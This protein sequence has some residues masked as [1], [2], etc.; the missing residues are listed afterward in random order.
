METSTVL[1]G[2]IPPISLP[3]VEADGASNG[4]V[5]CAIYIRVSTDEQAKE[6]HYSLHGQE[7]YAMA[8]IRRR[9]HEGWFHLTTLSDPGYSG[10]DWN[11]PGLL[12][13]IDL[14]KAKKV[15]VVIVYKRERLFRNLAMA[16]SIQAVFDLHNVKVLSVTEG[17][18]D[19][20]PH[21]VITRQIIDAIAQFEKANGRKRQHDMLRIAAMNGDWKGGHPPLGYK[22]EPGSR[23]LETI[24]EEAVFVATMFEDVATGRSLQDMRDAWR[25]VGIRGRGRSGCDPDRRPFIRTDD[26]KRMIRLP[27]YRGVVRVRKLKLNVISQ[28]DPNPEW[29]EFKGKHQ[30]IVSEEI[31]W[32]AN[33]AIDALGTKNTRP[34]RSRTSRSIYPLQGLVRCAHCDCGMTPGRSGS[35]TGMEHRYYRC[36]RLSKGRKESLCST[37]QVSAAALEAAV[38]SVIQLL[39]ANPAAFERIGVDDIRKRKD[40]AAQLQKDIAG[41]DIE[42]LCAQKELENLLAFVKRGE[43]TLSPEATAAAK[44]A[45]EKL[46]RY[47]AERIRLQ[48]TINSLGAKIASVSDVSKQCGLIARAIAVASHNQRVSIFRA[49]FRCIKVRRVIVAS[50]EVTR[51]KR[52]LP[53][54]IF[55]LRLNINTNQLMRFGTSA[56][57]DSFD[58]FA[59]RAYSDTIVAVTIQIRSNAKEQKVILLEQGYTTVSA[60]FSALSRSHAQDSVPQTASVE[61]TNAIQWA[62]RWKAQ[63]VSGMKTVTQIAREEN[64]SK[65]LVSQYVGLLSLPQMII[66]FLSDGRDQLLQRKFSLRELQRLAAMRPEDAINAFQGRVRGQPVQSALNLE[67]ME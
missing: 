15:G 13:L 32:R 66:D 30:P 45:K 55:R 8:E 60:D 36:I 28:S 43:S 63:L 20:S 29:E 51:Q 31:W 26:I 48:T 50:E 39:E 17:L 67:Q 14:V 19:S 4:L 34:T 57:G 54:R 53:Q 38:T 61:P 37:G 7:N 47:E 56:L 9:G 21:N 64:V 18:H 3:A 5:P 23:I 40:A 1:S 49:I 12:E 24:A 42:I 22:Y 46:A 44:A 41:V 27:I 33:R 58:A 65:G 2:Q 11:R 62:F 6:E 59:N 25:Q 16:T 10:D 52:I 35:K